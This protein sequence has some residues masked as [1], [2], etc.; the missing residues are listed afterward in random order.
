MK[1]TQNRCA[2]KMVI[3][4]DLLIYLW[5]RTRAWGKAPQDFSFQGVWYADSQMLPQRPYFRVNVLGPR[6]RVCL[7]PVAHLDC[8]LVHYYL[9][10]DHHSQKPCGERTFLKLTF[11]RKWPIKLYMQKDSPKNYCS[12]RN[13]IT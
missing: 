4:R 7:H 11:Y 10:E 9:L 5:N 1:Q 3:M 12:S 8:E 2:E 6:R 13:F